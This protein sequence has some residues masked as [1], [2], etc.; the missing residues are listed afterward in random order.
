MSLEKPSLLK[1]LWPNRNIDWAV[2][3][4]MVIS[5]LLG[6]LF[7]GLLAALVLYMFGALNSWAKVAVGAVGYGCA[8][9]I[10]ILAGRAFGRWQLQRYKTK[11]KIV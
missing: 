9:G 5:L 8:L 3:I 1:R 7:S 6:A 11:Q 10:G 2:V 4:V